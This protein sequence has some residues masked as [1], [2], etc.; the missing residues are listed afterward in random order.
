L[1]YDLPEVTYL[2]NKNV[3]QR[4]DDPIKPS[5]G[6]LLRIRV[7]GYWRANSETGCTV[8]VQFA[9]KC[10]PQKT[11]FGC[12][13]SFSR[14]EEDTIKAYFVASVW[15]YWFTGGNF[16]S[17]VEALWYACYSFP[18]HPINSLIHGQSP[19]ITGSDFL[20]PG[21]VYQNMRQI[22]SDRPGTFLLVPVYQAVKN[23]EVY[24]GGYY[25]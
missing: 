20:I 7:Q 3:R 21:G 9:F 8:Y 11:F 23:H 19:Y 2:Y 13:F 25:E 5:F 6:R 16:W 24:L 10:H 12:Y 4:G 18:I 15:F 1:N 14:S 22:T 17:S